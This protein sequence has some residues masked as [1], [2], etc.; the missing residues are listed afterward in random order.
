MIGLPMFSKFWT[1]DDLM[2]KWRQAY[3]EMNKLKNDERK[4]KDNPKC[5]ASGSVVC[6]P[7]ILCLASSN[8][9][10]SSFGQIARTPAENN[11]SS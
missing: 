1:N 6:G 3:N 5:N 10:Y 8:Y 7:V 2:D 9:P 4:Q 11:P